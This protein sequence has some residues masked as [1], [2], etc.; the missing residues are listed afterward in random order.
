MLNLS[1]NYFDLFGLPV[2]FQVN[3]A[4]LASR[5]RELQRVVHPDRFA[6]SD[7][8]SQRLSLQNAMLVNEAYETLRQPLNRAQYMLALRDVEM[9]AE[10]QGLN[11]PTFLMQQMELREQLAEL[12][13]A[14]DPMAAL[15]TLVDEIDDRVRAQVAELA[16]LLDDRSDQR[17]EMAAQ[18]VHKLQFLTKLLAEAEAVAADLEEA[19]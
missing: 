14:S 1:K 9:G 6:A 10:Q 11:D 3:M 7:S 15:G 18:A 5:Y 8:H 16:V 17:L 12:R 19:Y 13:V 4:E 2:S